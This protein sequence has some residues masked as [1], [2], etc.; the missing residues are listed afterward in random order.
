MSEVDVATV[1]GLLSA[2]FLWIIYLVSERLDFQRGLILN[3]LDRVNALE[4]KDFLSMDNP[5][6]RIALDASRNAGI[7]AS[8]KVCEE[9][10]S[11]ELGCLDAC[12]EEIRKRK[13]NDPQR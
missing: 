13:R 2:V 1:F 3:L 8:A 6:L 4:K 9:F 5:S 7:E 10:N 11:D 12:A